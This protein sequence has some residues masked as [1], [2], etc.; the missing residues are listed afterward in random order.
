MHTVQCSSKMISFFN[1][2]KV[3]NFLLSLSF[4][5]RMIISHAFSLNLWTHT[6][7]HIIMY[8]DKTEREKEKEERQREEKN[9]WVMVPEAFL[10]SFLELTRY[11]CS[12]KS[13]SYDY[14]CYHLYLILISF[15]HFFIGWFFGNNFCQYGWNSYIYMWF[16]RTIFK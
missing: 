3:Y 2:F 14:K 8:M 13:F 1:L 11:W 7:T 6:H 9:E 16:T 4:I 10:F 12:K 5:A 15:I